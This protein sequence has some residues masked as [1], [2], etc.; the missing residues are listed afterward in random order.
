MLGHM[1]ALSPRELGAHLPGA[2]RSR[3]STLNV[4]F[5]REAALEAALVLS[6]SV[7]TVILR[8]VSRSHYLFNWDSIQFALGIQRFD[9]LAHRPHPPGYLGYIALGRAFTHAA[10]GDPQLGLVLLSAVAEGLAVVLAYLAARAA[11]G[12]FAGWSA[13]ILLATSPLFW[14]YG[15][16]GLTYALEPAL[17]IGVIWLAMRACHGDR[18]ALAGA[19]LVAAVGGAIRPTDEIFL[20]MPVA[21]AAY[22][23]WRGGQTRQVLA[24]GGLGLAA[25]LAWLIPLI[26]ASGGIARYVV[27]SRELSAR[28]SATSAV[29]KLGLDGLRINVSAVVFAFMLALGLFLPVALAYLLSRRL[30]RVEALARPGGRDFVM[31]SAALMIPALVVYD[32]VHI[33]QMGYVLLLLPPILLPA[34]VAL[35][36]L[37]RVV[38]HR[39]ASIARWSA[40][41]TCALANIAIFALPAGG[42]RDQVVQND[43]YD[44]DVISVVRRFDP[45]TTVL[46]TDADAQG[47]YRLAQY[48][49]ADYPVVALGLD[50]R[51]HA[52]EM[53]STRGPAPQYDLARFDH[54]GAPVFPRDTRTV[55]VLD[56]ATL[57]LMG[58][59]SQL[60][61]VPFGNRWR[62]WVYHGDDQPVALGRYVFL[63][64]QDCPC[65]G[66]SKARPVPVPNAAL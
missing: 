51:E 37:A 23:L 17:T 33:G 7:L 27:A 66:A 48:Y 6:L 24:A 53:F 26:A 2:P 12:R 21:W 11:W 45:A 5:R 60:G 64:P 55:L 1:Q 36:S 65:R 22:C 4:T 9:L 62:I 29:W 25:T 56:S 30:L 32:F 54:A 8:L 61:A 28:A 35:D 14:I 16:V 58:D 13:S 46:V 50:R 43:R 44:A 63:R 20:A 42:L 39:R 49:L 38:A 40:L 34:G 41:A 59:S 3:A 57:R 10:G 31:L 47:S 52:G 15:G 19:A 18:H